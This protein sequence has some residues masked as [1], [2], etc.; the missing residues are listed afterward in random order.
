MDDSINVILSWGKPQAADISS[1]LNSISGSFIFDAEG[2]KTVITHHDKTNSLIISSPE[3]N[4]NSI[5]NI[6]SKLDIRRASF[7]RGYCCRSF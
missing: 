1:I 4:L 3:E 2:Q 6:V 7:C 5:R